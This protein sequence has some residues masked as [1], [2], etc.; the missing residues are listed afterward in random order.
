MRAMALAAWA[1]LGVFQAA[2]GVMIAHQGFGAWQINPTVCATD[3]FFSSTLLARGTHG[4]VGW[5]TLAGL[6]L[7]HD[8]GNDHGR[9][10]GDNPK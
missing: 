10:D 8:A 2:P 9:Q 7:R 3:H 6:V 5:I 4:G 1:A